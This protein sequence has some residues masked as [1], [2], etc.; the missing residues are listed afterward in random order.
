[1]AELTQE[2]LKKI[3][4]YNRV[5][6]LFTWKK[7]GRGRTFGKA[8]GCIISKGYV[9]IWISGQSYKAHRLAWLYIHGKFPE[10]DIDHINGI[11][12]DNSLANLR[13][14]TRAE[15]CRNQRKGINNTSGFKGVYLCKRSNK[16]FAQIRCRGKAIYLGIFDDKKEAALAYNKKALN[17]FGQFARL[18]E[19][20]K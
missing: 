8:V 10:N 17:V 20:P 5:S 4:H 9:H 2:L 1:M 11:R 16:W 6:G 18:N 12:D 19:I 3:L 7:R 14:C 13:A 15:N